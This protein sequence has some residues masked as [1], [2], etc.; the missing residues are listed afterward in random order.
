LNCLL[1]PENYVNSLSGKGIWVENLQILEF[2]VDGMKWSL[3]SFSA[4]GLYSE[5]LL[6]L[7]PILFVVTTGKTLSKI[8]VWPYSPSVEHGAKQKI[9]RVGRNCLPDL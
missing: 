9:L 6:K 8:Q 7:I 1:G 2:Q 3:T 4:E 5:K